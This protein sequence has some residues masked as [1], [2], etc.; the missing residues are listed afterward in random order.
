MVGPVENIKGTKTIDGSQ[1]EMMTRWDFLGVGD[2]LKSTDFYDGLEQYDHFGLP[3]NI[4]VNK[5]AEADLI[6]VY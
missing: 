3:E 2:P 4:D 6:I 1:Q 5:F